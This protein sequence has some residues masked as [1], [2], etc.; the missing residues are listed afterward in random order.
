MMDNDDASTVHIEPT[1]IH[2]YVLH[3]TTRTELPLRMDSALIHQHS[4]PSRS[5]AP[6]CMYVCIC[7][8]VCVCVCVYVN[9]FRGAPLVE[10]CQSLQR[11]LSSR[12][13]FAGDVEALDLLA[14]P[15]VSG[16][17][18]PCGRTEVAAPGLPCPALLL[19]RPRKNPKRIQKILRFTR[20]TLC[21][22]L[23]WCS[24]PSRSWRG[25]CPS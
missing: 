2:S 4:S 10:S 12:L 17:C 15:L 7:V 8:G 13:L 23:P 21:T 16:S 1:A 25:L 18:G 22:P 6:L 9:I 24:S 11:P 5:L 3:D 20:A 14:Y 19:H